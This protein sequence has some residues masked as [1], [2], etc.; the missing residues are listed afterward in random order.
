MSGSIFGIF[1]L[2]FEADM[3]KLNKDL[4]AGKQKGR[5]TAESL[6]AV[7]KMGQKA[8]ESLGD[9]IKKLA[10]AGAAM[11]T[12]DAAKE[13]M[14][15]YV[16]NAEALGA[17]SSALGL[18]VEEVGA[19]SQAMDRAGG[20]SKA[21]QG[22]LKGITEGLYHAKRFGF[23]ELTWTLGRLGIKSREVGGQMKDAFQILPEL[24][25]RMQKMS[26]MRAAEVGGKLGIDEKTIQVL[27][28]GGKAVDELVAKE[29]ALGVIQKQDVEIARKYKE[30]QSDLTNAISGGWMLVGRE[31]IPLMAMAA[32][33]AN[34]VFG[35]LREHAP[36]VKAALLGIAAAATLVLAPAMWRLA[37]SAFIAMAPFLIMIAIIALVGL[38]IGLVYDDF[39]TFANGGDSMVGRLAKRFPQLL[40]MI[41]GISNALKDTKQVAIDVGIALGIV[42]GG[43]MVAKVGRLG[44]SILTTVV[45]ALFS[46]A[47]A[48]W[49]A[50]APVLA[51][52]WPWL[53][54]AVVIAAVGVAAWYFW[55]DIKAVFERA[56]NWGKEKFSDLGKFLKEEIAKWAGYLEDF[57]NKIKKG[58]AYFGIKLGTEGGA[59]EVAP[60]AAPESGPRRAS[61]TEQISANVLKGQQLLSQTSNPVSG[62]TG[63]ALGTMATQKGGGNKSVT[64]NQ[65]GPVTVQTQATDANGIA[66][67]LGGAMATHT[68]DAMNQFADGMA[69]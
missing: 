59:P 8:A 16:E 23:S 5:E 37:A 54:L 32:E 28:Q 42:F 6:S 29:K 11:M 3:S 2:L 55:D 4:D 21:F 18:N 50:V 1:S 40:P 20:D 10:M 15:S 47:A 31:A 56:W 38:A 24:A 30:A 19:W 25:N 34:K 61:S 62:M 69:I 22:T 60:G 63:T 44:V 49:A 17:Y 13:A 45:P 35:N 57:W 41:K 58:A 51:L 7:D 48:T 39:I 14:A 67:A 46:M 68:Q 27:R 66:S 53:L 36:F 9:F 64:V 33:A 12:L 26:A 43:G 65:S 52:I